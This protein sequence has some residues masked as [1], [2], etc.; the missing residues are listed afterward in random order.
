VV[1]DVSDPKTGQ[2][3]HGATGDLYFTA[4]PFQVGQ[5]IRVRWSAKRKAIELY[6][7]T[8]APEDE[9]QGDA[10]AGG[11]A[12]VEAI[13]G[14]GVTPLSGAQLSPDQA[15]RVQEALGAL[16]LSGTASVQVVQT[17]GATA[18]QPDPISQLERL[19]E[20]RKSG[21]L[22]DAEFEQEKQR[23]LGEQ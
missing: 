7:S 8:T 12:L 3:V 17:Q 16:G 23:I 10:S 15:A 19:A 21:A 4:V 20:L 18:G 2:V 6:T 13:S 14:A 5:R 11:Q 9:W 1:A 22:T